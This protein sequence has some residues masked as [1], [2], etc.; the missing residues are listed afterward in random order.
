GWELWATRPGPAWFD[1]VSGYP[2]DSLKN[3]GPT[4][5]T[6]RVSQLL[7]SISTGD[8]RLRDPS[9]RTRL[10][11][12]VSASTLGTIIR[13]GSITR[14][15]I[16]VSDSTLLFPSSLGSIYTNIPATFPDLRHCI[17][18]RS[19]PTLSL[20]DLDCRQVYTEEVEVVVC[21]VVLRKGNESANSSSQN[22]R[23]YEDDLAELED[24]VVACAT[25]MDSN[26]EVL[27]Q[28]QKQETK[29]AMIVKTT[30]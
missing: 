15:H 8:C 20:F 22:V 29:M 2:D 6:V 27:E 19:S 13:L 26:E 18:A 14:L 1:Q 4:R 5:A 30:K 28:L 21:K 17:P 25:N 12:D 3:P 7:S 16:A 9:T 23:E 11:I 24:V 10:H